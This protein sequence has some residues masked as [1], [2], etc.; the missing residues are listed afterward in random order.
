MATDPVSPDFFD[1]D[2]FWETHK[3]KII[4]YGTIIILAIGGW[5][6]YEFQK[7]AKL[8]ASQAAYAEAG[9][10]AAL[11]AVAHEF[12]GTSAA[13][14]ATLKLADTFRSEGKYDEAIALLREFIGKEPAYP[15]LAGAWTSLAT[16]VELQGKTDEALSLY[17]EIVT[18]FPQ[19]SA[20]AYALS[21]QGRLL[22]AK[23][24]A[25]AAARIYQDLTTRYPE[26]TFA[27][28]ARQELQLLQQRVPAK[29]EP[30]KAEAAPAPSATP[31]DGE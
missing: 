21:A 1:T 24:D 11:Q 23:G 9:D 20:A 13:G 22:N 14:N 6:I 26:S 5:G 12:P 3:T 27:F 28:Q 18:K 25:Q 7:Q 31:A 19:E 30:D 8:T 17:Q 29:A 4:G 10:T 15:L 16:T 2:D